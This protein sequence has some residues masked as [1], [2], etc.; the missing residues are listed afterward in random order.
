MTRGHTKCTNEKE[1]TFPVSPQQAR[2]DHWKQVPE[3]SQDDKVPSV[4]PLYERVLAQV[5]DIGGPGF[6]V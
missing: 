5:R 6:Q 1:S 2:N 3:D 4:L